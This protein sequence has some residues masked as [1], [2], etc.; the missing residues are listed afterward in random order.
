MWNTILWKQWFW[1]DFLCG[2]EMMRFWVSEWSRKKRVNRIQLLNPCYYDDAVCR[3]HRRVRS[4]IQP[5]H[6]SYLTYTAQNIHTTHILV[7]TCTH[8]IL[9]GFNIIAKDRRRS[10][11]C[12]YIECYKHK[13]IFHF[14]PFSVLIFHLI[15]QVAEFL[16]LMLARLLPSHIQVAHSCLILYIYLVLFFIRYYKNI[17]KKLLTEN[18]SKQVSQRS[19]RWNEEFDSSDTP[20]RIHIL[21]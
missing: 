17:K 19:E 2:S 5:N 16:W 8:Y 1:C 6:I 4:Y 12:L 11:R 21:S 18:W 9:L 13:S 10:T 7:H 20:L 3:A 15:L 14:L